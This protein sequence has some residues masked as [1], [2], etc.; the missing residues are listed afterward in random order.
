M[1]EPAVVILLS[2]YNGARYIEEQIE[3]IRAQTFREWRLLIRDDGSSD[4]TRS[5]VRKHT[6]LDDRIEFLTDNLG[7]LGPWGSFAFLLSAATKADAAYVFLADQDDVWLA[8]KIE[9]QLAALR[10][11]E[12]LHGRGHP[13]LVHSDLELVDDKL[14]PLHRSFR[15]FQGITHDSDDPLRTLLL[16]NAVVGCTVGINRALLSVAVPLPRDSPHDWWLGLC[17]AATGTV[18]SSNERTVKYRQ[19]ESNAIGAPGKRGF[20]GRLLRHPAVFISESLAAFE[21][22]V[23]QSG[24]LAER[25]SARGL[26]SQTTQRRPG[27][28]AEAFGPQPLRSRIRSLRASGA[29]PRRPLSRLLLLGIVAVLP[30]WRARRTV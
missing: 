9:N 29:T 18:L 24:E 20:V 13:V 15:E 5:I 19:H 30:H 7:N 22:G 6:L 11:V 1:S 10:G 23:R 4:Q 27:D 25:I 3:S 14:S 2:S 17:A 26:G 8:S 12:E 16:H 21:V 28:Y